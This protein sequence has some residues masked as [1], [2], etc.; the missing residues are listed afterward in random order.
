[1]KR[2]V[3][4]LP[5]L[6]IAVLLGVFAIALDPV[7]DELRGEVAAFPSERLDDAATQL[8][9][10]EASMAEDSARARLESQSAASALR[11]CIESGM[12]IPLE[13]GEISPSADVLLIAQPLWLS[14]KQSVLAALANYHKTCPLRR[15]MPREELKSRLKLPPRLFNAALKRLQLVD[16]GNWL[17]LPEHEV[18][19]STEQQARVN[20]LLKKFAAAPYAPPSRID[21]TAADALCA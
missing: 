10:L 14:L 4:W 12:L 2:L 6:S 20:T 21:A 5:I 1:M 11:E 18:R 3:L 17:A 15:G 13:A 16:G 8:A 9:E 7:V 19:F